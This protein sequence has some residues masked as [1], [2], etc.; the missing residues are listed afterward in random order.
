M[1]SPFEG[2]SGLGCVSVISVCAETRACSTARAGWLCE[3]DTEG[4]RASSEEGHLRKGWRMHRLLTKGQKQDRASW[5]RKTGSESVSQLGAGS[6]CGMS[7]W[8]GPWRPF[9]ATVPFYHREIEVRFREET[10]SVR[11]LKEHRTPWWSEK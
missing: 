11:T 3:E 6:P 7:G 2:E 1:L 8:K 5:G 4:L 10:C 9:H